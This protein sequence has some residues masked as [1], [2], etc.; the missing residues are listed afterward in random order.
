M[1]PNSQNYSIG[2]EQRRALTLLAGD[3][4]G[5]TE[6]MLMARG[7]TSAVL[8]GLIVNGLATARH[9]M[10][11]AGARTVTESRGG[12]GGLAPSPATGS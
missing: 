7:F 8:A 5:A 2:P 1:A 6:E 4:H 10:V 11:R 12:V 9:E 3:P